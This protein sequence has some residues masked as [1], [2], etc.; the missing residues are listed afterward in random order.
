MLETSQEVTEPQ[1]S[2][3]PRTAALKWTRKVISRQ[4]W[5]PF[6]WAGTAQHDQE[7]KP[8]AWLLPGEGK[9]SWMYIQYSRFSG[10]LPE[11]LD[12]VLTDWEH[13]WGTSTLWMPWGH[14][15]KMISEASGNTIDLAVPQTE[16]S[17]AWCSQKKA[18]QHSSVQSGEQT[19]LG[20]LGTVEN[21]KEP[22]G[23]PQCQKPA[24][25]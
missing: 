17:T 20:C 11:G 14:R 12:S 10:G 9:N 1:A 19:Y 18:H 5:P 7:Q 6:P 22:R 13:W 8:D 25:P 23:W 21:K 16:A 3:K 2:L 24:D 4:R 15:E